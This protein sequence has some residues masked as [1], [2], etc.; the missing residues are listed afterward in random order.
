ML[1][2]KHSTPVTV[3]LDE[4]KGSQI[5]EIYKWWVVL[6]KVHRDLKPLPYEKRNYAIESCNGKNGEP[7]IYF[8]NRDCVLKAVLPQKKR[9]KS[10][11][12]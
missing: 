3:T 11:L 8:D 7:P 4:V 12:R 5:N 1:A 2:E 10:S 9:P 6:E